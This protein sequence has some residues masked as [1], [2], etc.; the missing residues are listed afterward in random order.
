MTQM[1]K[2]NSRTATAQIPF[3]AAPKRKRRWSEKSAHPRRSLAVEHMAYNLEGGHHAACPFIR[4]KGRWL[5][6]AG[7]LVGSRVVVAVRQGCL[8][9]K[10]VKA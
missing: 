6:H 9:I 4:L 5:A 7:F 8:T 2:V 10:P 3:G 1:A